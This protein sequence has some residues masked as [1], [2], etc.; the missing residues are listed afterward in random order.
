MGA[1]KWLQQKLV[2]QGVHLYG[3]HN[4]HTEIPSS[5]D[6]TYAVIENFSVLTTNVECGYYKLMLLSLL[7]LPPKREIP[8]PPPV[9]QFKASL[10]VTPECY[11]VLIIMEVEIIHILV[12]LEPSEVSII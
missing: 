12:S 7:L 8:F 6:I 11:C 9:A 5:K 2:F 4:G 3:A 1:H 10:S